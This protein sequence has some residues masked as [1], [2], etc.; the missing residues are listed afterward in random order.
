LHALKNEYS[1]FGVEL[2]VTHHSEFIGKLISEGKIKPEKK[3]EQKYTY[4]DSCYLGRYNNIY[5]SPRSS[6]L[7]VP[8][9]EIVE[10]ERSKDKGFCCGAGGGRM[11]MEETEGKRVN[12]ERTEEALNTGASTIASAC[13]FCM[14]MLTDGIKEKEKT[15]DVKI[16]DIAEIIAESL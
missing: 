3:T 2:E 14:T 10:M 5:D 6:L 12:V 13:P 11:F 4:H 7:S 1:Q 15:E 16:K 9:L 8:G